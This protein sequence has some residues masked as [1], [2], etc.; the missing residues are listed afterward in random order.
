[1]INKTKWLGHLQISMFEFP[2]KLKD[3]IDWVATLA[4]TALKLKKQ[5]IKITYSLLELD[6]PNIL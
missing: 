1:M 5:S 4:P 2:W 6:H 3:A